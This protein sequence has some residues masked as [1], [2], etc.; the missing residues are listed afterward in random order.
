MIGGVFKPG[1]GQNNS[2][3]NTLDD[4][5]VNNYFQNY[6]NEVGH[7]KIFQDAKL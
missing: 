5:S 1:M 6:R 4:A 3:I 7:R 2:R